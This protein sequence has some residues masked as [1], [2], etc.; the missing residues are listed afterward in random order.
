MKL[1]PVE[2]IVGVSGVAL[3]VAA[4][5]NTNPLDVLVEAVT[6]R[7]EGAR[8]LAAPVPAPTAGP[9]STSIG[10]DAPFTGDTNPGLKNPTDRNPPLSPVGGG[11]RLRPEAARAFLAAQRSYG[12]RIVLT[13]SYRSWN[14]QYARHLAHPKR[15]AHPDKSAHPDGLA[16]DVNLDRTTGGQ[17]T[18][19]QPRY[20]R[21]FSVLASHGW[22]TYTNGVSGH[23]WHFSYGSVR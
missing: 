8:P 15:F 4:V 11:H 2:W 16:I 10:M 12:V 23:T 21:L 5:G 1:G 18:I 19:R 7:S 22:R 6:G 9:G 13:D 3:I 17:S 14:T 20:Q